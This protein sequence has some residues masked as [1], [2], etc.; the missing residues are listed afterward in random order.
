[1]RTL[2]NKGYKIAAHDN[3]FKLLHK[4]DLLNW[5]KEMYNQVIVQLDPVLL[6]KFHGMKIPIIFRNRKPKGMYIV[7][8]INEWTG[9]TGRFK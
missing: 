6:T 4:V 2:N 3:I 7:D 9:V 8:L 1:M 5:D